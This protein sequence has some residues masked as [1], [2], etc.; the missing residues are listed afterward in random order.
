[1]PPPARPSSPLVLEAT[2][3]IATGRPADAERALRRALPKSPSDGELNYLLAAALV[4]QKRAPEAQFFAER[5]V[6]AKPNS[7]DA[8]NM[9]G[10]ALSARKLPEQAAASFLKALALKPT[11]AGCRANL[12]QELS[13][14]DRFAD[15]E[16]QYQQ[17]LNDDQQNPECL[18]GY[19]DLHLRCGNAKSAGPLLRA[20]LPLS[21]G[22][23]PAKIAVMLAYTEPTDHPHLVAA[24][25]RIWNASES[26]DAASRPK[27]ARDP[28]P[29]LRVG[30]LSPDLRRHS[31]TAFL[32]PL[33]AH[34]VRHEV[35]CYHCST[36]EDEVSARLRAAS[37]VWHNVAELDEPK[38]LGRIRQDKIDVLI[39][40]SILLPGNRISVVASKPAPVCVNYLGYPCTSGLPT[41]DYRIVDA[42]T[43]PPGSENG[44]TERLAR[45][46]G[47]FLCFNPPAEAPVPS[48][49]TRE[50]VVFGTFNAVRKI[51]SGVAALWSQV[52]ARVP[53][54][55]L[56]LKSGEFK[57]P[58]LRE[59]FL[60]MLAKAGIPS[61]RVELR[62]FT[63]TIAEHLSMYA[64]MDVA[65]D[66]FPYNGTTTTCEALYMGVPVVMLEGKA[67][68]ARV[69]A[70]IAAAA[71]VPELLA[72]D[73]DRYVE[74][75]TGLG[76]D[77]SRRTEY[78]RSLRDRL[79][80]SEL[81]DA[82]SAA[83]RFEA[84]LDRIW[85]GDA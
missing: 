21:Q 75:A 81:C 68:R 37:N 38:L 47:C 65:L 52:L 22:S 77:Q 30:F 74:I 80:S 20:A 7:A 43:D 19:A 24:H 64:D 79:L 42:R 28:K 5:A 17:G 56:L 72:P 9:L 58:W 40:L 27:P 14:Q 3:L 67:H 83:R 45:M 41:M 25:R 11:W 6:A 46:E 36:N 66:P 78:R 33:I 31:V 69:G 49:S 12:A 35:Y 48:I 62:N 44:T 29:S 70:S 4:V 16:A 53:N 26:H 59:R 32:E 55:T 51:N 15:A 60:A 18:E 39:D 13:R 10:L 76:L 85:V 54:S 71:G 73:A 34:R 23:A 57:E 82:P 2:H 1:M 61:D 8:H 63:G 50:G 84:V